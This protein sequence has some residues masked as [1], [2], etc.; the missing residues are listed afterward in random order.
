MKS[1]VSTRKKEKTIWSQKDWKQEMLKGNVPVRRRVSLICWIQIVEANRMVETK[2]Y[3]QTI[4]TE[5]QW[6]SQMIFLK[7]IKIKRYFEWNGSRKRTIINGIQNKYQKRSPT[8]MKLYRVWIRAHNDTHSVS[9]I[10][11]SICY[12]RINIFSSQTDIDISIE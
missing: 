5:R 7:K 11:L 4:G 8:H 9:F 1:N 10:Y 6:Q 3:V 2:K 12:A